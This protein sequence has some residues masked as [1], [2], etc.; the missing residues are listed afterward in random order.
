MSRTYLEYLGGFDCQFDVT[1][2]GH[3]ELAV[4]AQL[5]GCSVIN[6]GFKIGGLRHLPDTTGDHGPVHHAQL[7]HDHPLFDQKTQGSMEQRIR[8][9]NWKN[10]PAVWDRRFR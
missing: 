7:S 2:I 9:D 5:D 8:M 1:C 10:S 3:T 6:A 4:R